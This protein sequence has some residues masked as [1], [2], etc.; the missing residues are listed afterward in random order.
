[1]AIA[2]LRLGYEK[3][4]NEKLAELRGSLIVLPGSEI[5]NWF[6]NQSS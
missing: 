3:A 6:S 2:S 1:M 4:N 5:P